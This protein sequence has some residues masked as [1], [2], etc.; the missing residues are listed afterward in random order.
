M[1]TVFDLPSKRQA[2]RTTNVLLDARS[3]WKVLLIDDEPD[4]REI[5]NLSLTDAGYEV[6]CASNGTQGL[7]LLCA[8]RPQILITDIKMPGLSGLEVLEKTKALYPETEVIVTTGF[9]DLEKATIALQ[10]DASDFITKPVD[11]ARL[12][13][14]LERAMGRYQDKKAL[15]DYTCL[16]EK[17]NLKTSAELIQNVNYQR[18]LIENS[19]DGILGCNKN[20]QVITYNNAMESLLGYP[21]SQVIHTRK[22]ADFFV[23]NDFMALKQN[24][25][26]QGYGGKDRLFLYETMMK[27]KEQERIPVQIS[28]S[29]VIQE[30]QTRGLVLFIRDLQKIRDLEQTIQGQEKVLHQEKMMSLGRLSASIVHEINNP[31]SGILN[32]IR[33][34]IR[35][36][37]QG[38]LT[39][40]NQNR[41]RDYLE[42]VDRETYRCSELVSGLLKFSRKSKLEFSSVDVAELVQYSLMLC[43]HKI[44]LS[45][46]DLKSSYDSDLPR[47]YG[48]F[49][50]LQQC[51]INL[52]FNAISAIDAV[53]LSPGRSGRKESASE[54]SGQIAGHIRVDALY[55]T[56]L[57]RVSLRVRDDGKGISSSDLPYI[58]EPFFTTKNQGYGVGLG[59]STAYGIIERH[60]GTIEVESLE[61]KGTCFQIKLPP[62]ETDRENGTD[63]ENDNP[64]EEKYD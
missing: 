26:R 29:L 14:A 25:V 62:I 63:R 59:L 5:M 60:K 39:L 15:S 7:E 27:G 48:D 16:L 31:L 51:V 21:K 6:I 18:R 35:L 1:P 40:E 10:Q 22:L 58:F 13:L 52:V 38:P 41:F 33:L 47:V 56:E 17:E 57:N 11:D 54:D 3:D 34:M 23:H 4:I 42:M 46:I 32:Y 9:A 53:A 8:H 28:G 12:H 20:D 45:N 19:M 2:K 44:E 43:N 36:V 64:R 50:Q 49:N 61:G 24:L 55:D 37:D 30:G